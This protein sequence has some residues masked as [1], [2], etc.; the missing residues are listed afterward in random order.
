MSPV[1]FAHPA[2]FKPAAP[3][4]QSL[5][6]TKAQAAEAAAKKAHDL[7][8]VAN[9]AS[10]EAEDYEERLIV[11]QEVKGTAQA[12]IDEAEGL[13]KL[14][15]KSLAGKLSSIIAKAQGRLSVALKEIEAIYAEGKAKIDAATAARAE[16]KAAAAA[17]AEAQKEARAAEPVPVSVFISRKAQRLYVR[18]AFEPLFESEVRIANPN[19]PIGTTL[20]TVL[21]YT[22]DDSSLRWNA[23]AMYPSG[24]GR[25]LGERGGQGRTSPE[26]AKAAL[27]R[28]DIP[29]E[30]VDRI[31]EMISP[32]SSLIV[33]DEGISK[34]TGKGTDFIVLM[35]G[36]PQGGI[37][38]RPRN[39]YV[40]RGDDYY[41]PYGPTGGGSIFSWW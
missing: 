40:A 16:A 41:A 12:T 33:S 34:E 13:I 26:G 7:R 5:A 15:G 37:K 24:G 31:N 36:E 22:S 39:S 32:G 6:A 28:I 27:D 29:K 1:E 2:L 19:A 20:F 8:R 23:L 10:R 3:G 14:E 25:R 4:G 30:V 38:R 18:K 11:A 9:K 17:A 35:S 21:G